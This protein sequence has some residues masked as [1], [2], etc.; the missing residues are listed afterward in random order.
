MNYL[1]KMINITVLLSLVISQAQAEM[2]NSAWAGQVKGRADRLIAR[3]GGEDKNQAFAGLQNQNSA[4]KTSGSGGMTVTPVQID[5]SQHN[6]QVAQN[7]GVA[8]DAKNPK[9]QDTVTS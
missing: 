4:L 1:K 8:G 9:M 5:Q 2:K 7:I 6:T 3:M